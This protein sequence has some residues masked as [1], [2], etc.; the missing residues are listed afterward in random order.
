MLTISNN[1]LR[2]LFLV[3]LLAGLASNISLAEEP[4]YEFDGHTKARVLVDTFPGNSIF[5]ELIGSTA[6]DLETDVRLNFSADKDAWS[7]DVAWQLFAGYGDRIELSQL[8]PANGLL[9]VDTSPSDDRRLMNLTDPIRDDD[10]FRALHRFDRLSLGYA[11]E[12][13]V[14]RVGRQA[15]SWGNGLMFSPMDIVNPFDP[16]AV[17]TEYKVGDDM[18]YGQYLFAN[19]NDLQTAHVFRRSLPAG[20]TDPKSATTAIKYHG[21]R[22]DSEYDVLVARSYDETIF[23]LGGN[24]SIGGAVWRGDIVVSDIDTGS[25]AQL[26]TNLSYSWVLGGKNMS[27]LVEYYFNGFGQRSGRYDPT[28]L[29]QNPNLIRRLERGEVFTVGRN[30]LAGGVLIEMNPLWTLTPNLFSNLDDGSALFQVTTRYSLGDNSEFLAALNVPLGPTGTEF[31][32]IS[33]GQAGFY[34]STDLSL[35]TQFAWYF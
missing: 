3:T 23:G 35:F 19:G 25:K 30:Y 28:M 16:T 6:F 31:G 9:F 14:L 26:V 33:A 8:L 32:G 34:F 20:N 13:T 15:I 18:I 17:D 12:N 21:I 27:G 11:S 7:F 24:K 5:D 1:K 4:T 10:R 29:A 2:E 22:G